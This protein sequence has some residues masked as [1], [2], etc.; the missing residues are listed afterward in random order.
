MGKHSN[1]K[2]TTKEAAI[3]GDPLVAARQVYESVDALKTKKSLPPSGP[4]KRGAP[5]T[6][7][8]IMPDLRAVQAAGISREAAFKTASLPPDRSNDANRRPT[9][10][11]S[12][13]I[14]YKK[15]SHFN[16]NK[17]RNDISGDS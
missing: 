1:S 10:P 3:P 2:P 11:S 14:G 15:E 5:T 12:D 13:W 7:A 4:G 17:P 9:Q 16:Y 6:M 8:S